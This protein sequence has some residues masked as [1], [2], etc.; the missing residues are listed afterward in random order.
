LAID[1][2]DPPNPPNLFKLEGGVKMLDEGV[3]ANQRHELYFFPVNDR[4]EVDW[5]AE[6]SQ[7]RRWV[8]LADL[9]NDMKVVP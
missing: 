8:P 9:E 6:R 3:R 7:E 2:Y 4:E 1:W 5:A